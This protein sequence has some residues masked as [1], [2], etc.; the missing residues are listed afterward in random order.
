MKS[1]ENVI[2]SKEK[3]KGKSDVKVVFYL[4]PTLSR[5]PTHIALEKCSFNFDFDVDFNFNFD[6]KVKWKRRDKEK[7][8]QKRLEEIDQGSVAQLVRAHA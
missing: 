8:R 6:F 1:H 5:A 3:G 4:E 7:K 2:E